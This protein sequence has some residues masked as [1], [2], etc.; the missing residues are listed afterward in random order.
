M[1]GVVVVV[2]LA[3][4]TVAVISVV[5]GL[6]V[7]VFKTLVLLPPC[8]NLPP[9]GRL[10]VVVSFGKFNFDNDKLF[11]LTALSYALAASSGVLYV[12]RCLF[13]F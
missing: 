3:L 7:V 13:L 6:L 2:P 8:R 11:S 4:K 5:A 9:A 1:V 10:S 12:P